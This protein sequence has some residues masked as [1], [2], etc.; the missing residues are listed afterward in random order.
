MVKAYR[1]ITRADEGH[2]VAN[3]AVSRML[4]GTASRATGANPC[5]VK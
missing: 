2:R 4:G 1:R 3:C 5:R